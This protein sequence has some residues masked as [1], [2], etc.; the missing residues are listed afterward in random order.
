MN[1]T[2]QDLSFLQSGVKHITLPIGVVAIL[3]FDKPFPNGWERLRYAEAQA[4]M[5]YLFQMLGQWSIV[6]FQDGKIDGHGYGNKYSPTY[7][8]E[9]G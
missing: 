1:L 4:Y 5:Q 3:G 9:C 8:Q 2:A 7:G 6:A